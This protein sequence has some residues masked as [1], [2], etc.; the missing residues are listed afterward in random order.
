MIFYDVSRRNIVNSIASGEKDNA[1]FITNIMNKYGATESG[2]WF[3]S[4]VRK[5]IKKIK[6]LQNHVNPV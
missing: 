1:F 2:L 6:I 5:E 4:L 3:I